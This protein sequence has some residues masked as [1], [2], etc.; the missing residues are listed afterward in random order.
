MLKATVNNPK[1]DE[2][3]QGLKKQADKT[4]ATEIKGR[5]ADT[6]STFFADLKWSV[7]TLSPFVSGI[8]EVRQM[9]LGK[10]A[11]PF[12]ATAQLSH[13]RACVLGQLAI[14]MTT[15]HNVCHQAATLVICC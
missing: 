12:V 14:Y 15:Q 10:C 1:Y 5:V 13:L 3:I 11:Q 7:D 8:R 6:S 2:Y 9:Q 4:K